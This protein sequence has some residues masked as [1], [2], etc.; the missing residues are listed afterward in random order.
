MAVLSGI[1]GGILGAIVAVAVTVN[2]CTC[3]DVDA[4]T[5]EGRRAALRSLRYS[6]SKTSRNCF[7]DSQRLTCSRKAKRLGWASKISNLLM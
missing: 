2:A 6:V 5:E 7:W 1:A 3:A 4:G